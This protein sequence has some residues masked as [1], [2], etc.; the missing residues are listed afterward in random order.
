MDSYRAEPF[1]N[2]QSIHLNKNLLSIPFSHQELVV[3]CT[4][5]GVT[6]LKEGARFRKR[7]SGSQ[8]HSL[9]GRLGSDPRLESFLVENKLLKQPDPE[10]KKPVRKIAGFDSAE[11]KEPP[12]PREYRVNKKLI[13]ARVYGF[14]LGQAK[15]VLHGWVASFPPCVSEHLAHKALNTWLT[16]CR[17]SLFLREYLWTKERQPTTG[18]VH[19]HA[20][21]PQYLDVVKANRAM[22][23]ILANMVRSG[24]L[25]WSISGAAR[26]NGV[27]I[28]KH[29][30]TKRV[31]N[32]AKGSEQR[33]LA[34]YITKY[35]SKNDEEYSHLAWHNSR[36]FSSVMT[37]LCLTE[38]EA[39]YLGL[40]QYLNME[41]VH[42]G[43][44]AIWIGWK[45]APPAFFN[46]ALRLMNYQLLNKGP[47]VDPVPVSFLLN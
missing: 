31:T 8:S 45:Q 10:K 25:K 4:H 20:L 13:R 32:F 29:K 26:Y 33:S 23:V 21:I 5:T 30:N 38:A 3:K 16:V 34:N 18:T 14:L 44:Y 40:R 41:K 9:V 36:G 47:S 15:P 6:V 17:Q 42:A 27:H 37:G 12:A 28:M 19:F 39:K 11:V 22:A 43:E 24:E 1:K 35:V 7:A 2:T 46:D